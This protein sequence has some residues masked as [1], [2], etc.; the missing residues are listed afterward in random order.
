M[1]LVVAC[2]GIV[3]M[4][5]MLVVSYIM[6]CR[7]LANL[8]HYSESLAL[9]DAINLNANDRAEQMNN[10][11]ARSRELVFNSRQAANAATGTHQYLQPLASDLLMLSRNGAT[12][13]IA[14]KK[15]LV[16]QTVCELK[17]HSKNLTSVPHSA[18]LFANGDCRVLNLE[19]GSMANQNSNVLASPGNADLF[20][21]DLK[22]K[23]LIK[24]TSVYAAAQNLK[25]PE[26]DSDLNFTLSAM[27]QSPNALPVQATLAADRDFN[28]CVYLIKGGTDTLDEC[29]EFPSALKVTCS[30]SERTPDGRQ[31][32]LANSTVASTDSLGPNPR[33]GMSQ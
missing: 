30:V 4:A 31:S 32:T 18:W 21:Y 5:L 2:V 22:A 26:G 12:R 9:K 1:L 23:Y 13:V 25:L 17:S 15:R 27:P 16:Q 24:G 19:V 3:L 28:P 10:L 8:Q 7:N 14:E 33:D 20:S 11:V 29:Q 6:T